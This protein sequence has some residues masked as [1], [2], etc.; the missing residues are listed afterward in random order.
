MVI[1][2]IVEKIQS[3]KID[4]L[5]DTVGGSAPTTTGIPVSSSQGSKGQ[6]W[7][8]KKIEFNFFVCCFESE[9]GFQNEIS[10]NFNFS[11]V[12]KSSAFT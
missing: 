3:Q 8:R 9:L 2:K 7:A 11:H 6:W 1:S 12:N 5:K 10:T 4:S